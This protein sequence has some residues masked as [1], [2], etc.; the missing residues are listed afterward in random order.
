MTTNLT[1]HDMNIILERMQSKDANIKITHKINTSVDFLDVTISNEHGHLRTTIFHTPTTEP[2][3]LP[4]TSDHPTHSRRNIPYASLLRATRICSHVENFNLEQIRVDM[5]LLLNNYPPAFIQKQFARFFQLNNAMVI[6][7]EWNQQ[8]Y[9]QLH[10]TLLHQPTR[11]EKQLT[12]MT[13]DPIRSPLVLQPKIWNSLLLFPRYTF[14]SGLSNH[15]SSKF[16][17]WWKRYY[18]FAGSPLEQVT[19][20]MVANTNRTIEQYFIHKKPDKA[21][22]TKIET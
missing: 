13:Q 12:K 20:K 1:A 7:H 17:T 9:N 6:S 8:V 4:Y 22:V 14:D 11:R 5:S 18:A 2:Y 3:I 19:V 16:L 15:F 10:K 21:L